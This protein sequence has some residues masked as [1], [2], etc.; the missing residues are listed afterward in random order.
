MTT[1]KLINATNTLAELHR[2]FTSLSQ[3]DQKIAE[4]FLHDIQRGDVQ[5]NPDR[6]FRDYLADYKAKSKSKEI[7]AIVSYLGVDQAKLIALMNTC[8]TEANLNEYG[9]FDD[10]RETVDQQKAKAYFEGLEGKSLPMFRVNI[11]AAKLLYN[12]L[13]QGGI[14]LKKTS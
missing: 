11:K 14:D 4:I 5:I 3:E 12:F 7:A 10:L 9:R 2:S 6:T 1:Y 8:V 13:L